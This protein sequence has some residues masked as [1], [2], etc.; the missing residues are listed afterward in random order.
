MSIGESLDCIF[1]LLTRI[2]S[3]FFHLA[4]GFLTNHFKVTD[5][6]LKDR[7]T[8]P[9]LQFLNQLGVLQGYEIVFASLLQNV[10]ENLFG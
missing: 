3:L 4:L 5:Y 7:S 1:L 8:Q 2:P 6:F 10:S 9:F